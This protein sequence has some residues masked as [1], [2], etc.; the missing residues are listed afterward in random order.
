MS[1]RLD[2]ESPLAWKGWLTIVPT[3][4]T[5]KATTTTAP[6]RPIRGVI[7]IS[8]GL[9]VLVISSKAV[10]DLH[11]LL[12]ATAIRDTQGSMPATMAR[13]GL[14]NNNFSPL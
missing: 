5:T 11:M 7:L 2:K 3:T 14:H 6:P 13:P 1:L 4:T 10:E 12:T 8:M 9:E